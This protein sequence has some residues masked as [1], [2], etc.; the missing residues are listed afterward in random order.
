MKTCKILAMRGETE[1]RWFVAKK[2][3]GSW[4]AFGGESRGGVMVVAEA[5]LGAESLG[6][7]GEWVVMR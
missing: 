4:R 3:A 7:A 6:W 5:V 2:P 1:R